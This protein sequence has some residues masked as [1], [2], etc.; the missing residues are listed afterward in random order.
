MTDDGKLLLVQK[1]TDIE[2]DAKTKLPL[3]FKFNSDQTYDGTIGGRGWLLPIVESNVI[4]L[5]EHTFRFEMPNGWRYTFKRSKRDPSILLGSSGWVAQI[6]DNH[7][8]ANAPC[9]ARVEFNGGKLSSFSVG[10]TKI[11]VAPISGGWIV[12]KGGGDLLKIAV[13]G[14]DG[15][16]ITTSSDEF[17]IKMAQ[18]PLLASMNGEIVVER[19]VPTIERIE[20]PN[21]SKKFEFKVSDKRDYV[22]KVS[23]P[24]RAEKKLTWSPLTQRLLIDDDWEI[25]FSAEDKGMTDIERHNRKTKSVE[26]YSFDKRKGITERLTAG[27]ILTR[28]EWFT[29]GILDHKIKKTVITRDG[30]ILENESSAYDE[31]GRIL[32]KSLNDTVMQYSYFQDTSTCEKII[33]KNLRGEMIGEKRFSQSGLATY[34]LK[35]GHEIFFDGSGKVK[36]VLRDGLV[37]YDLQDLQ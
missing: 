17:K 19:M 11:D 22:L 36:K 12:R 33:T 18:R 8:T 30:E 20:G 6:R 10:D 15:I 7:I 14:K 37:V 1:L 26:R 5:D 27:N 24:K 13:L 35:N 28:K 25:K 2:I 32:R 31:K 21:E 4:Q 29:S 16:S 3:F 23:D 9:G 34:E